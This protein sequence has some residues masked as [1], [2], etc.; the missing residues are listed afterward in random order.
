MQRRRIERQGR[1][2][3]A[4]WLPRRSILR[5][6][7]RDSAPG[8]A[9]ICRFDWTRQSSGVV[10]RPR[11]GHELCL[12]LGMR[13]TAARRR[14]HRS[15]SRCPA[16]KPART[17]NRPGKPMPTTFTSNRR[18]SS[19]YKHGQRD[20][21]S[22]PI[23]DDFV[24]IAVGPVVKIGAAAVKA[25]LLEQIFV[26][27]LQARVG[28]GMRRKRGPHRSPPGGRPR[29]RTRRRRDRRCR[30]GRPRERP[31]RGRFSSRPSRQTANASC[32]STRVN[33]R[34]SARRRSCFASRSRRSAS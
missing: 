26:E 34:A 32:C 17:R 3:S 10:A 28:V 31:A 23:V 6:C 27:C 2:C 24:Q 18:A 8:A 11:E 4:A 33:C 5:Q 20:R 14:R 25:Q 7:S 21:N 12:H 1:R 16:R 13:D 19:I 22:F 9:T 29:G 30:S 15:V